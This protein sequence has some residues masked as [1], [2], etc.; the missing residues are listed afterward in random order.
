MLYKI[1]IYYITYDKVGKMTV[2][3]NSRF[4]LL[5]DV[6]TMGISLDIYLYVALK[7]FTYVGIDSLPFQSLLDVY[8]AYF[9]RFGRYYPPK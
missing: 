6:C 5:Y 1:I 4:Y 7:T 3:Y 2:F 8:P 9:T